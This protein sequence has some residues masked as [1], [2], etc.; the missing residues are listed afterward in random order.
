MVLSAERPTL[1]GADVTITG[2]RRAIF[3]IKA[4]SGSITLIP[5]FERLRPFRFCPD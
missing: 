4:A 3:R 2:S 5:P 1:N